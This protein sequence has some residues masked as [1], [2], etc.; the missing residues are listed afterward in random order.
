MSFILPGMMGA[1]ARPVLSNTYSVDL[2]GIN[3][4]ISIASGFGTAYGSDT[5]GTI[6]AW[7]KPDNIGATAKMIFA[8]GENNSYIQLFGYS[9]ELRMNLFVSGASQWLLKTDATVLST[10]DYTHIAITH[11]GTEPNIWINGV[12]VAA[13]FTVSTD[14]TLWFNDIAALNTR[15]GT[16]SYNTSLNMYPGLIDEVAYF[17]GVALSG[18]KIADIYNNGLSQYSPDGWWRMGD[19]DGGTG[20]TITDQGSGGNNATLQQGATFSTDVP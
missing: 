11:D 13:T 16:T 10:S 6:S 15:I 2:D 14:K 19:D 5:K 1:N 8:I 9:G 7:V 18:S 17:S 3:D 20:T 12:D 4:Y